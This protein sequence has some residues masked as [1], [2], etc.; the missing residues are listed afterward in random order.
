M[1]W[2]ECVHCTSFVCQVEYSFADD[3]DEQER[4][5][6]YFSIDR[7]T[8][9]ITLTSPLDDDR[10]IYTLKVTAIDGD[11]SMPM[12]QRRKAASKYI[13]WISSHIA[14]RSGF[15]LFRPSR[16]RSTCRW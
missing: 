6:G 10:D 14:L 7:N 13:L 5:C 12:D 4:N 9:D 1:N 3:C 15:Q 11:S 2:Y 8:G 16:G